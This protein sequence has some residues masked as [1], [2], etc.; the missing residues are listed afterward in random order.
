MSDKLNE[1]IGYISV[2]E[3]VDNL[4]RILPKDIQ[5]RYLVGNIW[6][7]IVA[8]ADKGLH[9]LVEVSSSVSSAGTLMHAYLTNIV[10]DCLGQEL[11]LGFKVDSETF[12][13]VELS[14]E[15][16]LRI[17]HL[18]LEL[19]TFAQS[20]LGN[21]A[22]NFQCDPPDMDVKDL[23]GLDIHL[24]FD[25]VGE[26]VR[27]KIQAVLDPYYPDIAHF[28]GVLEE[29]FLIRGKIHFTTGKARV[30]VDGSDPLQDREYANVLWLNNTVRARMEAHCVREVV[31]SEE[32][33]AHLKIL[34]EAHYMDGSLVLMSSQPGLEAVASTL[35]VQDQDN[36]N[37]LKGKTVGKEKIETRLMGGII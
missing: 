36:N 18:I 24:D 28:S 26:T 31:D 13:T 33:L 10:I 29:I 8:A 22:E 19:Y 5:D 14:E 15:E 6:G 17:E 7:S 30:L 23:E 16:I 12:D 34:R 25:P 37:Q 32:K 1:N 4:K 21:R 27:A 20:L 9:E 35:W 11:S 3:A 2:A